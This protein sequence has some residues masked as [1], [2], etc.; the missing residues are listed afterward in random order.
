M[1]AGYPTVREIARRIPLP[2]SRRVSTPLCCLAVAAIV[3]GCASTPQNASSQATSTSTAAPSTAAS[4]ESPASTSK[5]V[6]TADLTIKAQDEGWAPEVRN[7]EVIYCKDETPVDS[8]LP[9][10]TCL[11]KVGLQQLMLAEE[12]QREQMQQHPAACL[13]AGSC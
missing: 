8:R 7:G 10:R 4:A 2:A 9:K 3:T 11:N 13:Q 1:P 6:E 5:L 12:H